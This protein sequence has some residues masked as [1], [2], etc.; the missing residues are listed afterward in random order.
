MRFG[1]KRGHPVYLFENFF[2]DFLPL[3]IVLIISVVRGD[4]S[5]LLNNAFVAVFVLAGPFFRLVTYLTTCYSVDETT[6][7]VTSGWLNKKRQ[8]VPLATIT[9]VDM[10]ENILHQLTGSVKL[11]I[12]N[13]SNVSAVN[14]K[15]AMTF[16]KR[17]ALA[18][19][20]LLLAG[21][22]GTDGANIVS[23]GL[24]TEAAPGKT[25]CVPAK[26]LLLMGTLRSKGVFFFQ[27]IAIL[28]AG[29]TYLADLFTEVGSKTEEAADS[30]LGWFTAHSV[31]GLFLLLA[32]FLLLAFL[33]GSLGALI[34][35]YGFR[36]L[37]GG[38]AIRI[39]YGLLQKKSFTIHKSR[40]SGFRYEQSLLMRC[41]GFGLLHCLAIG[42]GA[43]GA[44]EQTA[45]EPLLFPLL[46]STDL[47]DAM[48]GIL[49]EMTG[50]P[51]IERCGKG[52]LRYFFYR[53][54]FILPLLL[55]AGSIVL[56]VF[57]GHRFL[58]LGI[59]LLLYGTGSILLQ[60]RNAALGADEA[61]ISV[62]EGGYKKVTAFVK[63]RHVESVSEAA[64]L[65][66]RKRGITSVTVRFIAPFGSQEATAYNLPY[67]C[68]EKVRALLLY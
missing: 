12:D 40:I 55:F 54:A 67:S 38:D 53:P 3:I 16:S 29:I 7:L 63:T 1:P 25:V 46:K 13:A 59:L 20:G 31:S 66:K 23:G 43:V 8:E 60:H 47:R 68:F 56:T 44:D 36:L 10:T 37:D 61:V 5:L 22:S 2:K 19:R 15:L 65:F 4:F 50:L 33:C 21:K 45:E 26:D 18:L 11:N 57:Y 35:Y 27:F 24:E 64:G 58:V 42:Y 14:T 28:I 17:D 41:F 48:A 52:T 6:L 30:L 39:E 9:T 34:K 32:A 62:A 51:N 49:P